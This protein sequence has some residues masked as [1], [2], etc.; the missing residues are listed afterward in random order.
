MKTVSASHLPRTIGMTVAAACAISVWG[1]VFWGA[2]SKPLGV[3]DDLPP[4]VVAAAHS[5]SAG[6]VATG[7]YFHPWP[8]DTPEA[9]K[10][11]L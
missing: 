8:R 2:L 1:M 11:W 9:Q 7:T 4:A 10:L 3:F 6:D 5:M